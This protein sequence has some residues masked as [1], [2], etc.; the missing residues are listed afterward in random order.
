MAHGFKPECV[1]T[2]PR[3]LVVPLLQRV[4]FVKAGMPAIVVDGAISD[5][6]Q[7]RGGLSADRFLS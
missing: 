3:R 2:E 4:T 5:Q 7:E 6:K 1:H